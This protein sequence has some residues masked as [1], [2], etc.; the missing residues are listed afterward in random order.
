MLGKGDAKRGVQVIELYEP[1]KDG[2][3]ST[4]GGAR[5]ATA[6]VALAWTVSDVI[7]ASDLGK[8]E[9]GGSFQ[10]CSPDD[11]RNAGGV[12][13]ATVHQLEGFRGSK[14]KF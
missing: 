3:A 8:E 7:P 10:G 5:A 2:E 4:S 6:R 13:I 12:L 11:F 14:G 1:E 9:K